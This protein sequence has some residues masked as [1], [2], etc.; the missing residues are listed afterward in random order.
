M[1]QLAVVQEKSLARSSQSKE[2]T[3]IGMSY[4]RGSGEHHLQTQRWRLFRLGELVFTGEKSLS[5]NDIMLFID[6][7]TLPMIK[8]RTTE[9][10]VVNERGALRERVP[11]P[12]S[13]PARPSKCH[14]YAILTY[15]ALAH[16]PQRTSEREIQ[17]EVRSFMHI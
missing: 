17:A 5:V 11:Q 13:Q 15:P 9:K 7:C 16:R 12:A 10:H 4:R 2:N 14:L 6:M 1:V 8:A 3:L